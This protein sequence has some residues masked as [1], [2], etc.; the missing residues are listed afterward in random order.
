M[1]C[2]CVFSVESGSVISSRVCD[3]HYIEPNH[4]HIA[5]TATHARMHARTD[6]TV[7]KF[8]SSPSTPCCSRCAL[9]ASAAARRHVSSQPIARESNYNAR[10]KQTI[11]CDAD[12]M[13]THARTHPCI[14]HRAHTR[15]R[16]GI[17]IL[18]T[19]ALTHSQLFQR[20]ARSR[21]AAHTRT[22]A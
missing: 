11:H 4:S 12:A 15:A 6:G 17:D 19:S 20:P 8:S 7:D 18:L 2:V 3:A 1:L 5:H 22:R 21:L 16:A 10:G 14:F 13:R 9:L